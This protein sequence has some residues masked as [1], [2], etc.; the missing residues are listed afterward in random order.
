MEIKRMDYNFSVCKVADYSL[1]KL[2]SEYSF[3][4]KT[5]E[6]KSLVCITEDV[7]SNVTEREDGW[8]AFRIQGVLDFSMIG[9]LSEISGILAENK[10]GIFVIST[11]NTD[12]VLTKKENY[13]RALDVLNRAGYKIAGDELNV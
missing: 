11:Y 8:M 13:Q 9:I 1:V 6:E 4:G 3:I 2:D 5:D 12:Y 7:P 10:I